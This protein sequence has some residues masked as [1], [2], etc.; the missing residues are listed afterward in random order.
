MSDHLQQG[1]KHA[2]DYL[3]D[4]YLLHP[5]HKAHKAR[6]AVESITVP[7]YLMKSKKKTTFTW[8]FTPE[9]EHG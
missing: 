4:R 1:L 5:D 3:G 7:Y 9:V 6:V 8:A 2:L